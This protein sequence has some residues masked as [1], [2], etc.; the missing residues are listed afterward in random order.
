MY[1]E[2]SKVGLTR[3]KRKVYA[4][5]PIEHISFK[6]PCLGK[7]FS[8]VNAK[9][10]RDPRSEEHREVRT[11][12]LKKLVS[13]MKTLS[14]KTGQKMVL[15]SFAS[16]L[17]LVDDVEP[18]NSE[19]QARPLSSP[20][21]LFRPKPLRLPSRFGPLWESQKNVPGEPS[22]Q[23]IMEWKNT[24]MTILADVD[25]TVVEQKTCGQASSEIWYLERVCRTTA[26]KMGAIFS[27]RKDFRPLAKQHLYVAPPT[28]L[29]SLRFG[30]D[31]EPVAVALYQQ[32]YPDRDVSECGLVIHSDNP[33]LAASPDRYVKDATFTP[34]EGLIEVKCLFA[35]K[36]TPEKAARAGKGVCLKVF[37]GEV[38]FN[39]SHKYFHQI[40]C[41][42]ACARRQWCDLVVYAADEIFCERVHFNADVWKA[43][44]DKAKNFFEAYLPEIIYP[45]H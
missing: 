32:R 3:R 25:R 30:R 34:S 39:T 18:P 16:K 13:G 21:D 11:D 38:K 44:E 17:L 1:V 8:A 14:E 42:M 20:F 36:D 29:P 23:Q 5:D 9:E 24:Y 12:D 4:T 28:S 37:D 15:L 40:Q 41:Q 19:E 35:T 2:T 22:A 27:R 10:R 6:K 7:D 33:W 45:D 26:S 43:C 31:K